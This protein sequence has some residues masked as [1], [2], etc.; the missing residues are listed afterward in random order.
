MDKTSKLEEMIKN[1]GSKEELH[2][3]IKEAGVELSDEEIEAIAGGLYFGGG[4]YQ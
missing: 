2:K 4:R 1:A 3:A